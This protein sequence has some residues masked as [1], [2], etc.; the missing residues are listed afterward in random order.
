MSPFSRPTASHVSSLPQLDTVMASQL[1][2]ASAGS[3]D[4][5]SHTQSSNLQD[6]QSSTVQAGESAQQMVLNQLLNS[7]SKCTDSIA[8]PQLSLPV[9]SPVNVWSNVNTTMPFTSHVP[10]ITV[11]NIQEPT[12]I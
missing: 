9:S 8:N 12:G 2:E 3:A 10:T 7:F 11:S 5:G 6:N 4:S 1:P